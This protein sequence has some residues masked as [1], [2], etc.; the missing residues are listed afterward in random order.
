MATYLQGAFSAPAAATVRVTHSATNSD[1]VVAV[2][3]Y[4]ANHDAILTAWNAQLASDLGAGVVVLSITSDTDAHTGTLSVTTNG[5]NFSITWSQTGDGTALRDWLGE[6]ADITN[7]P[8]GTAF[9]SYHRG[10]WYPK[11]QARAVLRGAVKEHR[12]RTLLASG[13]AET[14]H[15]RSPS[16]AL[17]GPF[18]LSLAFHNGTGEYE[19]HQ[20]LT[21]FVDDIHEQTG[22]V[23]VFTAFWGLDGVES[24]QVLRLAEENLE[25]MPRMVS[26]SVPLE[27]WEIDFACE[28][29]A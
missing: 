11:Y 18:Q 25:L 2:G 14:Q 23:P 13:N 15:N 19:G 5:G 6:S 21:D 12:S 27:Y 16:D 3:D 7:Q 9:S 22:A 28:V 29:A 20:R 4:Y 17:G 26:G 8:S 10:G 1:F 24:S